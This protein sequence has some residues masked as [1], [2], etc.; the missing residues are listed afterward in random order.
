MTKHFPMHAQ[1]CACVGDHSVVS[2]Q[3]Q[4]Q[5]QQALP[6]ESRKLHCWTHAAGCGLVSNLN[7]V[8]LLI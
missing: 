7:E 3:L 6:L 4:H 1:H 8:L 2:K 5:V